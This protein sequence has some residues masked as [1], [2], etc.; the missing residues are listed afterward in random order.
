MHNMKTNKSFTITLVHRDD[1]EARGFDVSNVDDSTM[2]R[3]AYKM[4][5]AYI[6]HSFW[7][8]LDII[9]TDL[10]IPRVQSVHNSQNKT[11]DTL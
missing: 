6:E 7:T 8:D 11:K 5:D 4:A 9:A 2:E 10:D 3:L 1:L